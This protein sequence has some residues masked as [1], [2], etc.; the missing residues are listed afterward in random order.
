MSMCFFFLVYCVIDH[1]LFA[2]I[3]HFAVI[4]FTVCVDLNW[5]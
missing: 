2:P 5:D 1:F 4:I 3:T